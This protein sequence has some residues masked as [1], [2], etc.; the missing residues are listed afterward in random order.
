VHS[1]FLPQAPDE[2]R[3]EVGDIISVIDMP[4]PEDTFWWRGKKGFNVGFFPSEH[5]QVIGEQVP[6]HAHAPQEPPTVT[7]DLLISGV[8][9]INKTSLSVI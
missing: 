2:L 3:L 7:Q 1:P 9:Q 8:I 4:P 5:V 6:R